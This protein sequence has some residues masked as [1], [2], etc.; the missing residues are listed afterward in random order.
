MIDNYRFSSHIIDAANAVIAPAALRMKA[1]HTIAIDRSRRGEPA[2]GAWS[3]LDQVASGRVQVVAAGTDWVS[4]AQAVMSELARLSGLARDWDWS[5]CAV[6][7]REW[8]QLEA[9]RSIC[10]RDGISVQLANEHEMSL[11]HLRETQSLRREIQ[12]YGTNLIRSDELKAWL[13]RQPSGPWTELLAQ[14]IEEHDIETGGAEMPA[15]SVI[16]WLAEWCRDTRRRQRGLLLLTA[17]RAK[18]LEFDHVV[19]LDGGWDM[20]HRDEDADASRRLYYVAMTRAKQTLTLM[21]LDGAHPFHDPLRDRNSVLWRRAVR[22]PPPTPELRRS[23][24]SLTLRDVYLSFAGRK[25]AGDRLHHS[26]KR[27]SPGDSLQVRR[28][29]D[30][31]EVLDRRGT[32]VG[33]LAGSF[34]APKGMHCVEASVSAIATW[35]KSRSDPQYTKELRCDQ[36]EVV[37]PDLVFEPNA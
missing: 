34:E 29:N 20:Q 25:P 1:K 16:E 23:Y 21:S 28:R 36:W 14:A 17:H 18:G 31:W 11:W 32:V 7:A 8:R 15:V 10:V 12:R 6:I 26:I 37:I 13:R 22:L 30:R 35:G 9:V 27:L 3:E 4:Q 5:R 24:R 2:G 33:M 19:V